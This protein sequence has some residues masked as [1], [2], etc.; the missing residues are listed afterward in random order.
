MKIT[1]NEY[2]K[3]PYG[4]GSAFVDKGK[5]NSL[6]NEYYGLEDKISCKIY[7]YH[8]L[9]IYHVLIPSN[10]NPNASYDVI[11][12]VDNSKKMSD[13]GDMNIK[14][15]SNCPSFIFTYANAFYT[16]DLLCGWLSSKYN[17]QVK[18]VPAEVRN[19][20]GIIGLERSIYLAMKYLKNTNKLSSTLFKDGIKVF[21]KGSIAKNVRNQSEVMHNSKAKLDKLKENV[22]KKI[23]TKSNSGTTKNTVKSVKTTK[24][25]KSMKSVKTTKTVKNTKTVKKI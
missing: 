24:T 20:Y 21:T 17:K 7:L 1:I 12:E 23:P 8:N 10:S 15:F 2:L 4:K 3:F 5:Q 14:V 22:N 16:N 11:I 25:T 13:L 19:R 9:V 6:D 18:K